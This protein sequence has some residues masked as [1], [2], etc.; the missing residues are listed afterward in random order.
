MPERESE[1]WRSGTWEGARREQL[2]R[3]RTL[4]L[5]EKLDALDALNDLGRSLIDSRKRRGLPYIDPDSGE[6]VLPE[7]TD[8]RLKKPQPDQTSLS[9]AEP[10]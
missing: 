6:R 2:L 3:W 10:T 1:S 4:S 7:K 5:K 9:S 8:L